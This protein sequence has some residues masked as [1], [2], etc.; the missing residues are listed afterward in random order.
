MKAIIGDS[1]MTRKKREKGICVRGFQS[2][3]RRLALFGMSDDV[4]MFH[5]PK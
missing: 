5:Q 3:R 2:N 4:L 1:F